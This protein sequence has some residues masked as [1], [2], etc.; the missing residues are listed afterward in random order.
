MAPADVT[1]NIMPL[2]CTSCYLTSITK[3]PV[4]VG[5]GGIKW[6]HSQMHEVAL[7]AVAAHMPTLFCA[8]H[9]IASCYCEE[10]VALAV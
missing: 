6:L 7:Q 3:R 10:L 5:A 2:P 1:L 4:K 9:A 8:R